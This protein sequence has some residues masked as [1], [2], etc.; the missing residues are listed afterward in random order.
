MLLGRKADAEALKVR[1][2]NFE[3]GENYNAL[4]R[5]YHRMRDA[6]N[7]A[8]Y[9]KMAKDAGYVLTGADKQF[10]GMSF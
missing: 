4:A 6:Q 9:S 5:M 3:I 10:F 2:D 1:F 8:L 7:T